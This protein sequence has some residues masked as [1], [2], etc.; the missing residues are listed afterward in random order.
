[1]KKCS[2]CGVEKELAEFGKRKISKDGLRRQC[3]ECVKRVNNLWRLKNRDKLLNYQKEYH[4]KNEENRK[5]YLDSYKDRRDIWYK[6][7]KDILNCKMRS[8]RRLKR[9]ECIDSLKLIMTPN[10][11]GKWIYVM[12]CGVY[13]KIGIS[14]NPLKRVEDI[15]YETQSPVSII[16]IAKPF[17]GETKDCEKI[18]HYDLK[19]FNIPIPYIKSKSIS[20]EWF[21]CDLMKIKSVLFNYC[22]IQEIN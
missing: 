18:I 4:K 9:K 7:N 3:K 11:D 14:N 12:K 17:Y 15:A 2:K 22:E 5:I 19:E 21:F 16:Y 8:Y 13:F 20:R 1:M 10:V 6:N